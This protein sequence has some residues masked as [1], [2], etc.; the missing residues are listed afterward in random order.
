MKRVLKAGGVLIIST[1]NKQT[2]TDHTQQQNPFHH[3]ELY[4]HEFKSLIERYFGHCAFLGQKFFIGTLL[5][6]DQ[7]KEI[8]TF[9]GDF[10]GISF[11]GNVDFEYSVAV[12]SE[13]PLRDPLNSSLFINDDLYQ[14]LHKFYKQRIQQIYSS[15]SYKLGNFFIRPVNKLMEKLKAEKKR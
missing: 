5:F 6:S 9:T 14:G 3:K 7:A 8:E 15:R 4:F 13:E 12:A 1:P 11:Q 10:N 2:Y